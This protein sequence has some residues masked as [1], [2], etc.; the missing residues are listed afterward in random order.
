MDELHLKVKAK[1]G[2]KVMLFNLNQLIVTLAWG[3]ETKF[4]NFFVLAEQYTY[5]DNCTVFSFCLN[6]EGEN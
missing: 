5:S 3:E 4:S 6:G 1:Q 2:E